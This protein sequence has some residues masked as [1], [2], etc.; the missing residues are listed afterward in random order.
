MASNAMCF[1]VYETYIPNGDWAERAF[2]VSDSGQAMFCHERCTLCG[3]VRWAYYR[4]GGGEITCFMEEDWDVDFR[5][6]W[7]RCKLKEQRGEYA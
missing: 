2:L 6:L 3:D 1:C 5:P 7:T 4:R